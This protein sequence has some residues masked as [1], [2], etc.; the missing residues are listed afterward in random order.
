MA[1]VVYFR[2]DLASV[3]TEDSKK[4]QVLTGTVKE[5]DHFS[6]IIIDG[7]YVRVP[8]DVGIESKS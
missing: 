4:S 1:A 5:T 3:K 7:S 6:S 2:L 8:L